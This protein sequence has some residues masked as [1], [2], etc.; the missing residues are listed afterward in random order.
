MARK[1]ESAPKLTKADETL[2]YIKA[3]H[4]EMEVM[5][6]FVYWLLPPTCDV[7][8]RI[9]PVSANLPQGALEVVPMETDVW[10]GCRV[11]FQNEAEG[12]VKVEFPSLDLFN[13]LEIT[14]PESNCPSLTVKSFLPGG[15]FALDVERVG[16]GNSPKL[17]IV[18]PPDPES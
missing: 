8:V 13:T 18:D 17:V 9:R 15:K 12:D 2:R 3:I 10:V 7:T 6:N 1:T 14:V 4:Q 5:R 11:G 16:S